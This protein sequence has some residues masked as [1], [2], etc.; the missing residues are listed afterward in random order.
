MGTIIDDQ[1][2]ILPTRSNAFRADLAGNLFKRT[3]YLDFALSS[4]PAQIRP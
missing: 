1:H 3:G 4:L 2:R